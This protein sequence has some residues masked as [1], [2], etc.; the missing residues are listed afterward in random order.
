M[1][2]TEEKLS[3]FYPLITF[4][5]F[6][7]FWE[8][9]AGKQMINTT[10]FPAPTKIWASFV[11]LILNGDM[12]IGFL[13]TFT[14]MMGGLI[15]GSFIGALMG[16][17]MGRWK[18]LNDFFDPFIAATYP[19]PKIAI[20]PL[21]MVIFGFGEMSKLVA[22]ILSAFFPML[23]TSLAGVRQ[24]SPTYFEVGKN[25]GARRFDVITHILLPGSLP[26]L[27]AGLRL[28]TNTAFIVTIS[29]EVLASNTGLGVLLWFGWQTFRVSELYAVLIV[30]SIF[31]VLVNKAIKWLSDWLV[32]WSEA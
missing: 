5:L 20:F 18:R 10:F 27:M 1:K 24:I 31:G 13:A 14:R 4:I 9:I 8:Y 25:Y 32:P 23:V 6:L 29:V 16:L 11:K 7:V 2:K 22:V 12:L 3:R 26:S 30:I 17:I 21:L 19:I 28:A 15:I